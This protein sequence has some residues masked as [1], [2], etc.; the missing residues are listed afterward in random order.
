VIDCLSLAVSPPDGVPLGRCEETSEG[1]EVFV[2]R[3][4][5]ATATLDCKAFK[6]NITMQPS[7]DR[8][9]EGKIHRVDRK[10]AR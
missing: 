4:S 5:K 6:G 8:E 9:A 7:S 10:F 1:S 3:W 2:R